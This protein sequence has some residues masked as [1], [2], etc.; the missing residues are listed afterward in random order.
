VLPYF[1]VVSELVWVNVQKI[2]D[3]LSAMP[4]PVTPYSKSMEVAKP[5]LY[6]P[7][8]QKLQFSPPR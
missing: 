5:A 3:N 4:I 6:Y 1:L 7:M 2:D 8:K